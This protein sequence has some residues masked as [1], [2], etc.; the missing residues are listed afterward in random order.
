MN[1][2]SFSW[3]WL[4][5]PL[6]IV[7]ASAVTVVM[8]SIVR[9]T[10][11]WPGEP[12]DNGIRV[13]A[14]KVYDNRSLSLMLEALQ[15]QLEALQSIDAASLTASVGTQQ[16]QDE[17][18]G[19]S[20]IGLTFSAPLTKTAGT[21]TDA[22]KG[23]GGAAKPSSP[24]GAA[25]KGTSAA[26]STPLK[27]SERASDLLDDQIN[28]SYQIFNLRLLLERAISDRITDDGKP[29]VQAVIALPISIDPPPYAVGCA[30]TVEVRLT[31]DGSPSGEGQPAG[32][33]R[34]GPS[35]V[36][37][38]PQEETYN[39]WSVNRRGLDVSAN[40]SSGAIGAGGRAAGSR[41]SA[42]IRRQA[43]IVAVERESSE[44]ELVVAWQF[45]PSPGEHSVKAGLR[46][47][48]AVVALPRVDEGGS[49]SVKVRVD[50]R[51]LWRHWNARSGTASAGAGWRVLFSKRPVAHQFGSYPPINVLTAD[52]LDT[53]LAPQIRSIE[54]FRVGPT[55]ACVLINGKNFFTGSTVIMGDKVFGT[56]NGL[57]I[58]SERT[59]Q[60]IVPLD[61]LVNDALL[62]GRYG[63]SVEL[64]R[65]QKL[66][67]LK[68]QQVWV[69]PKPGDESY[70]VYLR[71]VA[72]NSTE[73]IDWDIVTN[74]PSPVLAINGRVIPSTLQ[75]Y[76]PE[77]QGDVSYADA[78]VYVA[79][80]FLSGSSLSIALRWPF[81][82]SDWSLHFETYRTPGK[83]SA[84]RHAS[85]DDVVILI[86]G[87][88]F[89]DDAAVIVDRR[90]AIDDKGALQ[91]FG[92]EIKDLLKLK[93][94]REVVDAHDKLF[95]WEP[96]KAV[97][98]VPIPSA[99]G[100]AAPTIDL[101]KQPPVLKARKNSAIVFTGNGLPPSLIVRLDGKKV[102]ESSVY[103]GGESVSVLIPAD[104]I[105]TSGKYDLEFD[106]G[107][108]LTLKAPVFVVDDPS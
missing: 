4:V 50:V 52:V 3:A 9:R 53:R 21:Q 40:A 30:A 38:F 31:L 82:G 33:E 7:A 1:P 46:Q 6:A 89:G 99:Q 100:E 58:K 48:L 44:K 42:H 76:V 72:K 79:P 11:L 65:L 86:V 37:L 67:S 22:G 75:F 108:G 98:V 64:K 63:Q 84:I 8:L 10:Q 16:G 17:V 104:S 47:V 71:L 81:L 62:N 23:D 83:I 78:I 73:P 68:I 90:Y 45:R 88:D 14:P 95:V 25:Q 66:T 103:G 60:L 28:L 27:V 92:P 49:G 5:A 15:K 35:L 102:V 41:G 93:L 36:A 77:K 91:R 69:D 39:T 43:D 80:D 29:L 20:S 87:R 70:C 94:R 96:N 55:N 24:D 97:A 59:L 106:L 19:D 26:V 56:E 34:R 32:F 54:W 2:A 12:N 61:A 74:L 105:A 107:S 101:S 51:S 13:G 85:G 57:T 18:S